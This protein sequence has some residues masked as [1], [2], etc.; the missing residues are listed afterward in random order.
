MKQNTFVCERDVFLL[1]A[2]QN[3]QA[4]TKRPADK[5]K[6]VIIP[7]NTSENVMD[8]TIYEKCWVVWM[9]LAGS[10]D[11]VLISA[12]A[13]VSL[14]FMPTGKPNKNMNECVIEVLPPVPAGQ[15]V[16]AKSVPL[17][18]R[19]THIWKSYFIILRVHFV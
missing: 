3:G 13:F 8:L 11:A 4:C 19:G 1:T 17:S 14:S 18:E 15:M 2:E 6:T 5:L 16:S 12:S 7:F 9:P 10:M